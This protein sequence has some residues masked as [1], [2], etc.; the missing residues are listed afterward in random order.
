MPSASRDSSGSALYLPA[1]AHQ[2]AISSSSIS[3]FVSARS[4]H[5]LGSAS[6][7]KSSQRWVP[8]LPPGIGRRRRDGRGF[9]TVVPDR[10]GPEH[11]IELRA[12]ALR[13][14][15]GEAGD[16]ALAL[17]R[18]LHV[19]VDGFGQLEADALVD[20]RHDVDRMR[21][22]RADSGARDLLRP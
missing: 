20:G 2:S 9:P 17:E 21:V 16:E 12:L 14:R 4:W 7:L 18:V 22:L 13:V 15:V 11:G 8:K 3:G 10:A 6:A 5:S 19:T 1:S